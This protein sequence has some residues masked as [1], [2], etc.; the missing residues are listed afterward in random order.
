MYKILINSLGYNILIE[1]DAAFLKD[2]LLTSIIPNNF[3]QEYKATME[4]NNVKSNFEITIRHIQSDRQEIYR[5]FE[6]DKYLIFDDLS[7]KVPTYILAF[8]QY[9]FNNIHLNNS[10]FTLHSAAVQGKNANFIFSGRD[11][12]GK[13]STMIDLVT[14]HGFK[15]HSNNKTAIEI[16]GDEVLLVGGA[17]GVTIRNKDQLEEIKSFIGTEAIPVYGRTAF[18]FK[19]EYWGKLRDNKKIF[20]IS[21]KIN[22]G[23]QEFHKLSDEQAILHLYPVS[24]ESIDREVLMFN[25]RQPVPLKN[26]YEHKK[27]AIKSLWGMLKKVEVYHLSGPLDFISQNVLSLD[28]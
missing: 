21:L 18:M 24:I 13:T 14:N 16:K 12:A 4:D 9:N 23:V 19:E 1:T 2:Y 6:N 11:G 17:K 22:T 25:W 15:H 27:T 5:N 28:V 26:E 10:I 8:I 20:I 7:E 3:I